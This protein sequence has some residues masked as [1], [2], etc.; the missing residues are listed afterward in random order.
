MRIDNYEISNSDY[1]DFTYGYD[2]FEIC[3]DR[4]SD[5]DILGKK[6]NLKLFGVS[7]AKENEITFQL[8]YENN[9]STIYI[10]RK[11]GYGEF[12]IYQK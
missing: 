7:Y 4:L 5:L 10:N 1:L 11:D 3:N 9:F 6:S 2:D 12:N 8:F